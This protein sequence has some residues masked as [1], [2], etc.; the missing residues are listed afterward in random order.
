LYTTN[1]H[2]YAQ[3]ENYFLFLFLMRKKNFSWTIEKF[4]FVL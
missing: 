4:S 3:I 1:A 2:T